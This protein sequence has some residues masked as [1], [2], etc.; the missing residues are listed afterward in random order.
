M[1]LNGITGAIVDSALKIHRELGPGLFESVYESVL[2]RSLERR[3]LVVLC[4]H[5]ISF[6]YEGIRFQ[7]G[8]RIDLLVERRVIVELKS[9]EKLNPVHSRQ[10]LT[11]LRL[12][13]VQVGLLINFGAPTLK[14]G[15]RR[16]IN[17]RSEGS[18]PPRLC[19]KPEG[20]ASHAGRPMPP[21][22]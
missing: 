20:P 2:A 5:P 1:E 11:Y 14:E 16:I 12:T 9:V 15:L 3:G 6:E 10:L 13:N 22:A 17:D 18:A 19:V 7:E 21:G 8:F 4:Q